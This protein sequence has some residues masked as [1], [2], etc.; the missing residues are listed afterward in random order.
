M[1][2]SKPIYWRQGIFLQSQHFQY[3]DAYH[4]EARARLL[5]FTHLKGGGVVSLKLSSERLQ[6]GFL[7]CGELQ[8]LMPDGQWVD[9]RLNARL[10]DRDIG[11]FKQQDGVYKVA[12]GLLALNP[13]TPAVSNKGLDGRFEV[14]GYS[15]ELPDLYEDTPDLEVERLWF[16]L[17]YLV[18]DEI[19]S[20]QNMTTLQVAR[21]TVEAG[22]VSLDP[23][24]AP[25]TLVFNETS[26]LARR[27]H[28]I[29]DSLQARSVRLAEMSRPWRM[30]GEPL[31]PLWLR[32]RM[33]HAEVCQALAE[34]E[35]R[36]RG[37]LPP[38]RLFESL[39]VLCRRL[40]AIGGIKCPNLPAWDRDNA[41]H[42]FD[43]LGEIVQALLEQLRSGPDSV[44]VFKSRE[45][46]LEA[47]VPSAARVG[48]HSV[49]LVLQQVSETQLLQA[50]PAKLASLTRIETVVSRALP[51]VAVT[52][53]DRVP[54]GLGESA[55]SA[56]WRVDVKDP[57]WNEANSSGTICL[58]WL[59][60][61]KATRAMLVY[62]RA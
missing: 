24:Y 45:G 62:F 13:G 5:Q 26:P 28:L 1:N 46:W 35:H 31:D 40:S 16:K 53:L 36:M 12:I 42:A 61:P 7:A 34:L 39:L 43:R 15:E 38:E 3:A 9:I 44:A 60:L 10:P 21:L 20:A 50:S 30:D 14:M 17:R 22:V 8:A 59:G 11:Q 57:I 55:D 47:K 41:F 54:Y 33:V 51:G 23:E 29:V 32:D 48:E 52:R 4:E 49:Y 56:V 37:Q 6:S 58:H 19:K 27:I 25:A 2:S 18:G